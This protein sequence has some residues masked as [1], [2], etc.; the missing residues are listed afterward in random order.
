MYY[1]KRK[2]LSWIGDSERTRTSNYWGAQQKQDQ[3]NYPSGFL[4]N[5]HLIHVRQALHE[6]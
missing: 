2:A 5:I 6:S 1:D 4:F 3:L